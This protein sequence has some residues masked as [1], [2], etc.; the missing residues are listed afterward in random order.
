[1]SRR[2]DQAKG[3]QEQA[4]I[5]GVIALAIAVLAAII[6]LPRAGEPVLI[7]PLGAEGRTAVPAL[8]SAPETLILARG[9]LADSYVIGGAHPGFARGLLLHGVLLL[10]ATAPGC[11]PVGDPVGVPVTGNYS[12]F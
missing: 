11:G 2:G 6:F 10:N 5:C 7:V 12:P 3:R 1:M 8:L 9:S 4:V